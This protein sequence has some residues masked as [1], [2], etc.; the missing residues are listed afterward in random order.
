M[1][2][3]NWINH[4]RRT[5]AFCLP[6]GLVFFAS[7]T[8]AIQSAYAAFADGDGNI[9]T[10][11]KNGKLQWRQHTGRMTGV[12]TWANF[13]TPKVVGDKATNNNLL[14][15]KI[16]SG[17]DGVIY[18]LTNSGQLLWSR[19][20]GR[21]VGNQSWANRNKLSVIAKGWGRYKHVFSAG[22]GV[23]YAISTDGK[24]FWFRHTGWLDG[25]RRWA[26]NSGRQVGKGWQDAIKVF[27][28]GNGV[29]Y[30]TVASGLLRWHR[31]NGRLLGTDDWV[32]KGIHVP[33]AFNWQGYRQ[34]FSG[35][36]GIIYGITANGNVIWNRHVG[37]LTGAGIWAPP[38]ITD[39]GRVVA[40]GWLLP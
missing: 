19:H 32:N 14:N 3:A 9:Y 4:V 6:L 20:D 36:D 11:A 18:T 39:A 21:F 31:H 16:F 30:S 1:K 34:L 27:S 17:D 28:G 23:I 12:D 13:G 15:S 8:Y 24:M 26:A 7:N 38:P 2:V 37:W 22:D 40:Q 5:L 35:G 10:I 33:V 29:I 25:S